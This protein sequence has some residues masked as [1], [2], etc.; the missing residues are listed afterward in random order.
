MKVFR[1]LVKG[2][3]SATI[4][5]RSLNAVNGTCPMREFMAEIDVARILIMENQPVLRM[6]MTT[7]PVRRMAE[8]RKVQGAMVAMAADKVAMTLAIVAMQASAE[9]DSK[10]P[11]GFTCM[12]KFNCLLMNDK[13]FFSW[14]FMAAALISMASCEKPVIDES[15]DDT[16]IVDNGANEGKV[17]IRFN[18]LNVD[19][20][21]YLSGESFSP[22][23]T[24]AS[25]TL[26]D[27]CKRLTLAVFN[28]DGKKVKTISQLQT[29]KS[30]GQLALSLPEATY[31][32][33]F[34]ADNGTDNP[35]ISKPTEV[36]FK[37]NK[38]TDT[39]Y[40]CDQ[41]TLDDS[42]DTD[43]EVTL[44][45]AV[46]MFRL[47]VND[48]TPTVVKQMKFYYTGGSSTFDPTTGYGSV[49][50]RQTEY[51]T[52][53]AEAYNGVSSYDVY[54]FP[55]D[56]GKKLQMEISA[57]DGTS[58]SASVKYVRT[59]DDVPVTQNVITTYSGNFFGE[60]PE[61]GRSFTI[62]VDSEW[63]EEHYNY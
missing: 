51:R 39:F 26:R 3:I 35:T 36:K 40:Y 17:Q 38:V 4:A 54:T 49:N 23:A 5:D 30:F 9:D 52:V 8:S 60:S 43:Y 48:P 56:G 41:L 31:T 53:S 34:I 44:K 62:S 46:A 55:H 37:D 18:A 58:S 1:H 29:D 27:V 32:F 15:D 2:A 7:E 28:E 10:S 6:V 21:D 24:R 45:R 33:V 42:S 50:S 14:L 57:L 19:G 61:G 11:Y 16:E 63:G 13:R 12:N 59:I 22:A 25:A 20:A 47:V